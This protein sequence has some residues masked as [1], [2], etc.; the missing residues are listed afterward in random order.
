MW[1]TNAA[2]NGRIKSEIGS[3]STVAYC[4]T[5]LCEVK[6]DR[7]VGHVSMFVHE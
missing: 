2:S 7:V 5:R 1:Q 4:L 3:L 6:L